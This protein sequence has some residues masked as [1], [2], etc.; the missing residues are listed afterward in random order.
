MTTT[1][2]ATPAV[3]FPGMAGVGDVGN[4]YKDGNGFLLLID[5]S[6]G[7]ILPGRLHLFLACPLA[8]C[9]AATQVTSADAHAQLHVHVA[10]P[11]DARGCM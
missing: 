2:L 8:C 6:G 3:Y 4:N 10:V 1:W 11:A 9:S 7:K 5:I